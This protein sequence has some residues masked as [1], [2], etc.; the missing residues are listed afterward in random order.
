MRKDYNLEKRK[1]VI[2]GFIAIIV[3]IYLVRL[4]DLQVLDN[5]Y[6]DDADSN[7]F[8]RKAIYPSRGVIYDRNGKVVVYNRPAYDIMVIPR[9]IQ[10]FDTLDFCNTLGITRDQLIDR[11]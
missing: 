4:F 7:A 11:F 5:R 2:G 1:Y 9:D 10:P 8:L 3:V 6:K